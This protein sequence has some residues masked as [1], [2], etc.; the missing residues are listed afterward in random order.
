[1]SEAK[2]F[3]EGKP[4]LEQLPYESLKAIAEVFAYGEGK[5]SRF[6]WCAG[7]QWM[8]LAG[9]CCRHLYK[10]IGGEDKDDESGLSHLAHLGADC[11]MLIWYIQK[12]RG[13]DDRYTSGG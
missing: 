12:G 3:D 4:P 13:T 11:M 5:Y 8:K 6:N 1:M 7:M 2:H 9:S 10:W